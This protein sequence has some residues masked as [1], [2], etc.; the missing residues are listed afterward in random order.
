MKLLRIYLPLLAVLT[1][2]TVT[3]LILAYF[4]EPTP[5][6]LMRFFMGPFFLT[7]ASFKL[8]NLKGFADIYQ[9]YDIIAL[10][11]KPWAYIY[12]FVEL[13]LGAIYLLNFANIY[14]NI[15]TMILMIIGAIGVHITLKKRHGIHCACL[16]AIIKLPMSKISLYE[17][18]GM[19]IMAAIMVFISI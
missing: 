7:F 4:L 13:L 3:S 9:T 14:V 19:A 2:I 12:P 18:V 17:D 8:L 5:M 1:L 15:F 16:G 10:R 11:F 6:G